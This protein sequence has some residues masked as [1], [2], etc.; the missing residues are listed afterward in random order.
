M[1]EST[2]G[3]ADSAARNL[4]LHLRANFVDGRIPQHTTGPVEIYTDGSV[5][6]QR[7]SRN[8]GWMT[9]WGYITTD[10]RYGC[11]KYPQFDARTGNDPAVTTELRAVWHA[12]HAQLP[13][14]PVTVHLDSEHAISIL[15]AW[16]AGS[17]TMPTG[18][19]GGRRAATLERLR[20]LIAAHPNRL[21]LR[22]VHGH[23]GN[24][25]NEAADTLAQLGMRWARDNLD[26]LTVAARA[27]SI[28]EGFLT[29]HHHRRRP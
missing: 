15:T 13:A 28:A 12:T 19:R 7:I 10:G 24:T 8:T 21:T 5:S 20:D 2:L 27:A 26:H 1:S 29:D 18:Y 11:G 17:T 16:Q 14:G 3:K 4:P 22:H 23:T 25:L 6:H 9:G